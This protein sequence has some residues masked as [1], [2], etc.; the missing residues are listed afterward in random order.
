MSDSKVLTSAACL[1]VFSADFLIWSEAGRWVINQ[2]HP[3]GQKCPHCQEEITD[4]TRLERWYQCER[5]QCKACGRFFTSLTG[6]ILQASQ[7]DPRE[8][9]LLA[10]LTELEV[11]AAKIAAV[12]DIHKDTVR[13]WQRKFKALAEVAGA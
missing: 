8:V 1:K 3:A 4:D 13:I 5:I 10:V 2:L 9:Y 12:I 11:P 6:T 7:L